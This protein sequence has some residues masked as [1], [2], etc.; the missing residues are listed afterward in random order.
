MTGG[1]LG[2]RAGSYGSLQQ[3]QQIQNGFSHNLP[4]PG[5]T[6]KS[7]KLLLSSSREKERVLP[8]VCRFLGRKR[9][10]MLLL[11]VLAL[12]VFVFNSFT[13]NKGLFFFIPAPC[14]CT[15]MYSFLTQGLVCRVLY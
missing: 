10:T 8:F 14:T 9:V 6:R 4:A 1:S 11:V 15:L 3:L 12:L 5:L 13:V 2:L 7:S